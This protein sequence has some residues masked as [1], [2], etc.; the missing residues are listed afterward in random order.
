MVAV[1][2]AR[3]EPGAV[4]GTEDFLAAIGGQN[5][6]AGDDIDELVLPELPMPLT[7]P[8][9]RRQPQQVDTELAQPGRIAKP[10]S[11]AIPAGQ[12]ERGEGSPCRQ[13]AGRQQ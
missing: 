10:P 5:D 4:A 8:L 2:L 3:F 1:R 12:V 7:T 11:V 6:F 13:A 9:A